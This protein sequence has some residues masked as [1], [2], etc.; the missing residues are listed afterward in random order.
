MKISHVCRKCM[1]RWTAQMSSFRTK[2]VLMEATT[3]AQRTRKK[4]HAFAEQRLR[5]PNFI[6]DL[7]V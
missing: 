5:F 7:S 3:D 4:Q 1:E 2:M 6:I